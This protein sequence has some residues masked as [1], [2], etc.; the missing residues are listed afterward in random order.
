MNN[1]NSDTDSDTSF[2]EEYEEP[3]DNIPNEQ[4]DEDDTIIT[5]NQYKK[6]KNI[7][8]FNKKH[9]KQYDYFGIPENIH[10]L[11]KLKTINLNSYC[12]PNY[13]VAWGDRIPKNIGF[14]SNLITLNL[15]GNDVRYWHK[16]MK[17]LVNLKE[18]HIE[19]TC[20]YYDDGDNNLMQFLS[21]TIKYLVNLEKLNISDNNLMDINNLRI[22]LTDE[23][24]NLPNLKYLEMDSLDSF[25]LPQNIGNMKNIKYLSFSFCGFDKI[26]DSIEKLTTLETLNLNNNNLEKIPNSFGK[27]IN[28]KQLNLDHNFGIKKI[29]SFIKNLPKLQNFIL[30]NK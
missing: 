5:D 24:I 28:L 23:I 11:T 19:H 8:E 30:N 14:L 13:G 26:P 4:Y 10:I 21:S 22:G 29:P 16:S 15:T 27:L 12:D 6:L 9:M 17:N 25:E 7:T 20:H 1:Y 3:N 18:L 2:D